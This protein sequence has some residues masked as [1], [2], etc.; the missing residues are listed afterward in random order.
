MSEPIIVADSEAK[1]EFIK[2]HLGGGAICA[3]CPAGPL[4]G[5]SP[6]GPEPADRPVFTPLSAGSG[7]L[8]KLAGHKGEVILALGSHAQAEFLCWRIKGYLVQQEMAPERIRRLRPAALTP[9]ALAAAQAG[10][11]QVDEKSGQA[12]WCR[13]LFDERLARHLVR[14]IGVSSG[15]GGLPLNHHCLSILFLLAEHERE[16]QRGQSLPVWRLRAGLSTGESPFDAWLVHGPGGLAGGL[17]R[18]ETTVRALRQQLASGSLLVEEV[19]RTPLALPAPRPYHL[20]SL[21]PE[22]HDRLDLGLSETIDILARLFEGGEINGQWRGLILY[23]DQGVEH[24]TQSVI[25]RLRERLAATLGPQALDEAPSGPEPG[26][27]LPAWPELEGRKLTP[28][29]APKEAALYDL[30]LERVRQGQLRPATGDTLT[31]YCRAENGCLFEARFQRLSS[32]GFLALAPGSPA[33]LIPPPAELPAKGQRF[34]ASL[35]MFAPEP[36][37]PTPCTLGG[38]LREL[39]DFSIPAD[40]ATLGLLGRL[41]A[42][43]YVRML[44]DGSLAA[45]SQAMTVVSIINQAFPRMPGI[46]LAAYLEQTV[47][48][49]ISRR[50]PLGAALTQFDQ[51]MMLHGK[52][53]LKPKVPLKLRPRASASTIIKQPDMPPASPRRGTEARPP[54]ETA[55]P[56]PPAEEREPTLEV[57]E[58]VTPLETEPGPPSALLADESSPAEEPVVEMEGGPRPLAE[59]D[60]PEPTELTAADEPESVPAWASD[61][62]RLFASSL[63]GAAAPA[64]G[65]SE[66]SPSEAGQPLAAA[67]EADIAPDRPDAANNSRPGRLCPACG[68]PMQRREDRFGPF[69]GCSGFPACRHSETLTPDDLDLPC[70]L[71]GQTLNRQQTPTGRGFYQCPNPGCQF[72][73][74]SLPH[75]LPCGICESPYLIEK[76]GHGQ[77]RLCCPRAG[78]PYEQPLP[79]GGERDSPPLASPSGG[80]TRK[81]RLI[82]RRG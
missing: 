67:T 38:L 70:P 53:R 40:L 79:G 63:S 10:M 21:I 73:S 66:A 17:I 32:P 57:P 12:A 62:Q 44:Q 48:E 60:L 9:E 23:P 37:A 43:G 47:T 33:G 2:L 49:A 68:K 77:A 24:L 41:L 39:T 64:S 11:G 65:P 74:W 4:V 35:A 16:R 30:I 80:T 19:R 61:L 6:S 82:R 29:L 56:P 7:L 50:K 42:A 1:A 15:P 20:A 22:A 52:V 76:T 31:V 26:M 25:T 72:M 34:K 36:V 18:D 8:S 13:Q 14:L 71:C 58:V 5:L 28:P 69:W 75:Y 46:N 55:A 59:P 45:G 51:T 27:I 78:C 81:V 54:A 3:V